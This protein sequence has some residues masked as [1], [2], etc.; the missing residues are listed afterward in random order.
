MNDLLF[1][2]P[3]RMSVL[4]TTDDSYILQAHFVKIELGFRRRGIAARMFWCMARACDK[5]GIKAIHS[6]GLAAS[7]KNSDSKEDWSG[8]V[9]GVALGFDAQMP[10]DLI[11]ALPASLQHLRFLRNVIETEVGEKWWKDNPRTL[12]FTFDPR[13]GSKSMEI[14]GVYIRRNRIHLSQ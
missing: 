2:Q 8:A 4:S 7:A 1:E 10:D 5:L 14:L 11:E 3:L 6:H 12:K 13:P 9:A